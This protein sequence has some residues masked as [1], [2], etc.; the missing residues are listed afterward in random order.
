ARRSGAPR[1]RPCSP[2]GGFG[3]RRRSSGCPIARTYVRIRDGRTHRPGHSAATVAL[4]LTVRDALGR[5]GGTQ[6]ET[7]DSS[8][9]SPASVWLVAAW[10]STGTISPARARP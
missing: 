5:G 1:P 6:A 9:S 10:I 7:R 3:P 2:G 4:D 8:D